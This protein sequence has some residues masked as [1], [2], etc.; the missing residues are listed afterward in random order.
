MK[1]KLPQMY[2]LMN[3]FGMQSYVVYKSISMANATI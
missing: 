1:L 2:W 3:K